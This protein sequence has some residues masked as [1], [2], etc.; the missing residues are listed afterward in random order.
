MGFFL[1][2]VLMYA[3]YFQS[4]QFIRYDGTIKTKTFELS[5]AALRNT[6]EICYHHYY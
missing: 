2:L 3:A 1:L 5:Q 4:N 6:T